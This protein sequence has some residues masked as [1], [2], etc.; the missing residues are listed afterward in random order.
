VL[1]LRQPLLSH[2][3]TFD[4]CSAPE[5]LGL[6]ALTHWMSEVKPMTR[7]DDH[8]GFAD[9]LEDSDE[10]VPSLSAE[11]IS[12]LAVAAFYNETWGKRPHDDGKTVELSEFAKLHALPGTMHI[13][14]LIDIA[15]ITDSL[16]LLDS[17][18]LAT[19]RPPI[20]PELLKRRAEVRKYAAEVLGSEKAASDWFDKP[21][22]VVL[23][24][25]RPA[26]HLQTLEGC[27]EV[28]AFLRS[29]YPPEGRSD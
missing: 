19:A 5:V 8:D 6:L 17:G 9:D 3:M 15:Q 21:M 25:R 11:E 14:G 7:T 22:T 10:P 24:R 12:E 26:E 28:E 20:P 4:G 1:L 27:D 16:S 13:S 23:D 2:N 18:K 29:F